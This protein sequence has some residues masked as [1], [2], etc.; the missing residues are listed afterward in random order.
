MHQSV[1]DADR[2]ELGLSITYLRPADRNGDLLRIQAP[3]GILLPN[4]IGLDVDGE[5]IGTAYFIRCFTDGCWADVRVDE[6][7]LD[8]FKSGKEAI[9]KVFQTPEEGIGIP[10][11][12]NGFDEA[13]ESLP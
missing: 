2:E 7:L 8:V 4:G 10:V 12:L 13:Y 11:N 5:D 1:Q 9:F 6:K 3:L